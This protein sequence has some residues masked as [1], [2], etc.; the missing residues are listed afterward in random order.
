MT[1]KQSYAESV[2]RAKRACWHIER[3]IEKDT[4]ESHDTPDD[5]GHAGTMGALVARLEAALATL[6]GKE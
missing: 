1:A 5:W 4:R 6:E 2:R 3:A